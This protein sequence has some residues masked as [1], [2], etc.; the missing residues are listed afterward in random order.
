M[1]PQAIL[2]LITRSLAEPMTGMPWS[3]EFSLP[4]TFV[5]I[6]VILLMVSLFVWLTSRRINKL[7]PI[8]ALRGGITTHSFKKNPLPLDENRGSLSILLALKQIILN[9][10]QAIMLSI[11][12]SGLT[13]SAVSVLTMHYNTNVNTDAFIHAIVGNVPDVSVWLHD[14]DDAPAFRQN[15]IENP[16]VYSVFGWESLFLQVNE[17]S[18][19]MSIVEDFAYFTGPS[20]ISGRYPLLDSEIVLDVVTLSEIGKSVGDWVTVRI[21]GSEYKYIIAGSIQVAGGFVGMIR[22]DGIRRLQQD[23]DFVQFGLYLTDSADIHNFMEALRNNINALAFSAQ[24]TIDDQMATI[25][26]LFSALGIAITI[27]VAAVVVLVLYLISKTIIVRRKRELGLQKALGFTTFQLM[28]QIALSLTP[29]IIFGIVIGATGG[30]IGFNQ[31]FLIILSQL[32]IA[33]VDLPVPLSWIAIVSVALILLAYAVSMAIAWRIRKISAY[34]LV[35]SNEI[36]F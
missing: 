7:H 34:A 12:V 32:G 28:N 2:P 31:V 24:E 27:V 23:F 19:N 26:N 29:T 4:I 25:A 36:V 21:G 8:T 14:A 5:T 1:P 30:Y 6:I 11:I 20:L 33:Q 3:P 15:M 9:K 16:D 35:S 13:F 10:K 18:I 22:V 17:A